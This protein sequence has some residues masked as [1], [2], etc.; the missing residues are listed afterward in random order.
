[1][2]QV[3]ASRRN[4][5]AACLCLCCKSVYRRDSVCFRV[6]DFLAH[7]RQPFHFEEYALN[8]VYLI[9]SCEFAEP[10]A[11]VCEC[12]QTQGHGRKVLRWRLWGGVGGGEGVSLCLFQIKSSFAQY[13]RLFYIELLSF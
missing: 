12:A 7:C 13:E 9:Y 1:M 8:I 4:L 5:P 3:A 11:C 10:V 2:E 6:C